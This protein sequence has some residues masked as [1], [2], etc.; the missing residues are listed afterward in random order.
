MKDKLKKFK[1]L[2]VKFLMDNKKKS[3]LI[4]FM[5]G[6]VYLYPEKIPE[7]MQYLLGLIL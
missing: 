6:I 2:I 4:L 1:D 7:L 5:G 3:I